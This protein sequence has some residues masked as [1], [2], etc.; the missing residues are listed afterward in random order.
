MHN[1]VYS[2]DSARIQGFLD[3]EIESYCWR[4]LFSRQDNKTEQKESL[5][6]K[7]FAY[8]FRHLTHLTHRAKI[9]E[10]WNQWTG[11]QGLG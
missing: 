8:E 9:Q 11:E 4:V 10:I 2:N 3:V 1:I 5:T 6:Y 7:K